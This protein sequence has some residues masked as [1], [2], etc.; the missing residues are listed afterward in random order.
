MIEFKN[1]FRI[2]YAKGDTYA[3]KITFKNVT[4]DLTT[5]I[6]SVKENADDTTALIEKTIGSGISKVD[7]NYYKQQSVYKLQLQAED[8]RNLQAEHL[9]LYDLK[10]AVDNVI[11]TVISGNFVVRYNVTSVLALAGVIAMVCIF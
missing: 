8:S 9:Y 11:K 4:Q 5:A 2:E 7:D 6:F 3:L 1:D 10:V